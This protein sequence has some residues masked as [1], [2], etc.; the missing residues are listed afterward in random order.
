MRAGFSPAAADRL[1]RAMSRARSSADMEKLRAPFVEGARAKGVGDEV[2][3]E[4]FRQIAAFAEFGFCK[5]HAA[6]FALTAYHTAHL[7]LYYPSEFYVALLNNQPMGFYSPA[8][9]AGDA[10][11]HGVA[12]LPVV[13]RIVRPCAATGPLSRSSNGPGGHSSSEVS[14]SR[15]PS[16]RPRPAR[17]IR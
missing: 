10:K 5:S 1:R 2:A 11:R 14:C 8:V 3:H 7:K 16:W 9:I 15:F 17:P 4:I 12:I 13:R 6:A